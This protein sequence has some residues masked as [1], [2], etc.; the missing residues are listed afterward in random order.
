MRP[1]AISRLETAVF[2]LDA[3]KADPPEQQ[4]RFKLRALSGGQRLEVLRL[5][6]LGADDKTDKDAKVA[7]D[8]AR[9][10]A[11][12][13]AC[14]K[15]LEFALVG[16]ENVADEKGQPAPWPANIFRAL[17]M[18]PPFVVLELGAHVISASELGGPAGNG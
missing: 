6:G 10:Q 14:R 15:A 17:D 8:R 7:N 3:D 2:I 5:I 12:I 11:G 18:L 4:T 9:A 16:W 1:F 13:D